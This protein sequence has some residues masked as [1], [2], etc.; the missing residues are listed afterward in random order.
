MTRTEA[1]DKLNEIRGAIPE[2][3][4]DIQKI[5]WAEIND[6]IQIS[7]M[8]RTEDIL[9]ILWTDGHATGVAHAMEAQRIPPLDDK[10]VCHD[11][12]EAKYILMEYALNAIRKEENGHAVD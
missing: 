10:D 4:A 12:H 8:H 9:N 1:I 2:D 6:V 3:P 7:D 11:F 5:L